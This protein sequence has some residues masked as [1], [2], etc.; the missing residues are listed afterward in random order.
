M[1][2]RPTTKTFALGLIALLIAPAAVIADGTLTD[3]ASIRI[4]ASAGSDSHYT[5]YVP[6]NARQL[7]IIT[8]GGAGDLDLFLNVGRPADERS[9]QFRS[10]GNTNSERIVVPN[11]QAGTWYLT[12]KAFRGYSGATLTTRILGGST[13]GHPSYP[14]DKYDDDRPL[15]GDD[16]LRH[17]VPVAN[18]GGLQGST[19]IFRVEVPHGVGELEFATIHGV[20]D[21]DLFVRRGA[22]PTERVYDARSINSGA[23]ERIKIQRPQAGTW[24]VMLY[25][26]RG[27]RNV[28]GGVRFNEWRDGG[29]HPGGGYEDHTRAWG[30]LLTPASGEVWTLGNAYAV[31]W[32]ASRAV[33]NVQIQFTTDGGRTWQRGNMPAAI[34]ASSGRHVV[35]LPANGRQFISEQVLIRLVDAE[36]NVVLDTS[37]VFRVREDRDSDPQWPDRP[38]RPGR[39]N[40]PHPRDGQPQYET[41]P[42]IGVGQAQLRML[43][44]DGRQDV[45]RFTPPGPGQY[46][47]RFSQPQVEIKGF[48][49]VKRRTSNAEQ[50]VAQF[51]AK[52]AGEAIVLTADRTTEY[53]KIYFKAD[54]DDERGSYTISVLRR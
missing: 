50:S 8:S 29:Q 24:Y 53:F 43:P 27:Y 32:Q 7:E 31:T 42:L 14:K 48:V 39:P 1:T 25:A 33:R 41:S 16:V 45:L 26:Y 15:P 46:V 11:P 49:N 28:T 54:D 3:N 30:R 10:I 23:D 13:G 44:D 12:V 47:L 21:V 2:M 4:A 51:K 22:A 36:R 19:R 5:I 9:Y 20:G 34:A 35:N 40:W 37:G 52:G 38:G 18:L 6:H 17:G